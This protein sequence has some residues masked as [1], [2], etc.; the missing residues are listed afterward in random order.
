MEGSVF[1]GFSHPPTLQCHY[2]LV[3]GRLQQPPEAFPSGVHTFN[4]TQY[5]HTID[6]VTL[7]YIVVA[8]MHW[9]MHGMQ[10]AGAAIVP[11]VTNG[12]ADGNEGH[13]S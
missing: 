12:D 2:G 4:T 13:Q 1:L 10:I 6:L 9:M 7:S 3:C 11:L 5:I 8:Y